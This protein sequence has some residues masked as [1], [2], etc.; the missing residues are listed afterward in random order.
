VLSGVMSPDRDK[1]VAVTTAWRV[2]RLR[3]EERP[4]IWRVT[5]NVLN[6]LSRTAD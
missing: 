1:W 2:L 4:A 3:V 6:R 5:A